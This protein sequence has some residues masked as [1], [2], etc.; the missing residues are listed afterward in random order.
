MFTGLCA[1]ISTLAV[2]LTLVFATNVSSGG[3]NLD[4]VCRKL[5]L[6]TKQIFT[7][8][9]Q[10]LLISASLYGGLANG[11]TAG[12]FTSVRLYRYKILLAK[13]HIIVP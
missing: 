8:R 3:R 13:Q 9:N 2:L 7:S 11:F 6:V 10:I 5:R 1:G 4:S 12:D